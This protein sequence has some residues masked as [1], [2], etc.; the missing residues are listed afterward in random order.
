M[1]TQEEEL[2]ALLHFILTLPSCE[3]HDLAAT[4]NKEEA[5]RVWFLKDAQKVS[6][7]PGAAFISMEI[8]ETAQQPVKVSFSFG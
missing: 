2:K 4:V 3:M 5:Y 1:C 8:Q 6:Y 7:S